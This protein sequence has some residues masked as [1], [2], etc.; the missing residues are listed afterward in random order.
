M[1]DGRAPPGLPGKRQSRDG[2][3]PLDVIAIPLR[4]CLLRAVVLTVAACAPCCAAK[5]KIASPYTAP[6]AP[7]P[8][9]G[10]P[11]WPRPADTL[12]RAA[13][14]GL[15]PQRKESFTFHIHSHVDI[16]ANGLSVTIPA[17]LGIDIADPGVRHGPLP[18]GGLS[19]GGISLC[20]KPCISPLHT[21]APTGIVHVES[22]D[23]Q[24]YTLGRFFGEWGVRLDASC[25]GGYCSPQARVA[26]F[27]NG[28]RFDGNPADIVFAD[29][30]EIAIVIGTPPVRIPAT[31]GIPD[32]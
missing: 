11:P 3:A 5:T 28:K 27:V 4:R 7:T 15:V 32:L 22:P 21:H 29:H 20:A 14:E 8:K 9:T 23:K 10:A 17:G 1:V 18:G 19:Y 30:E 24:D 2:Y 12:A 13:K 16:F 6:D 26:V 31:Y 25:V